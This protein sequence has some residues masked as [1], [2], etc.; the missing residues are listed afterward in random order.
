MIWGGPIHEFMEHTLLGL[1]LN[2]FPSNDA[3]GTME[4]FSIPVINRNRHHLI[5]GTHPKG[6]LQRL[7]QKNVANFFLG[8]VLEPP[9][10]RSGLSGR[11]DPPQQPE[12]GEN[13]GD[14]AGLR[15]L[16]LDDFIQLIA[17][18]IANMVNPGGIK[19]EK[20]HAGCELNTAC[21]GR[22]DDRPQPLL[23]RRKRSSRST[24]NV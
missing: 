19:P 22:M 6:S 11:M 7:F 1:V 3:M 13:C 15:A 17:G 21:P 4:P 12:K 5:R 8:F 20:A 16:H 23:S 18:F 9:G 2:L 10:S 24:N 14:S